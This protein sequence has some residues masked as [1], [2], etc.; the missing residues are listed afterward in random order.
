MTSKILFFKNGYFFK[1][2]RPILYVCLYVYD[3]RDTRQVDF[4]MLVCTIWKKE[5]EKNCDLYY[6]T[7]LEQK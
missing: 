3:L 2:G 4:K 5:E 7:A 6:I 1:D